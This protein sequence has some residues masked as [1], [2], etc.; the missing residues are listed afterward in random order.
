MARTLPTE[1][2]DFLF[3]VIG[4]SENGTQI[5]VL[6]ALVRR[7]LDPWEEAARLAAMPADLA[8]KELLSFLRKDPDLVSSAP[9]RAELAALLVE[10]L[11]RGR[12]RA[13]AEAAKT[14]T[15]GTFMPGFWFAW[16]TFAIVVSLISPRLDNANKTR[17]G[18]SAPQATSSVMAKT[19]STPGSLK[20]IDASGK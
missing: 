18:V 7:N 17:A 1:Y 2:D 14:L 11:A 4:E 15:V 20:I 3:A 19:E 5:S 12:T 10:L 6:S 13:G 8:E 16:L 9:R